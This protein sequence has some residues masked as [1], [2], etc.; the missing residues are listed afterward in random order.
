MSENPYQSPSSTGE[1]PAEAVGVKSGSRADLPG[2]L[3]LIPCI[4]QITL[5]IVDGKATA[6]LEQN[7]ISVGFL[8]ADLSKVRF[9]H[10]ARNHPPARL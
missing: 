1:P 8:G 9:I 10:H 5:L 3:T 6:V 7:G 4:N 2:L